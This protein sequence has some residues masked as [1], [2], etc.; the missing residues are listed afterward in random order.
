MPGSS[1]Q[2]FAHSCGSPGHKQPCRPSRIRAAVRTSPQNTRAW[3]PSG[4][5]AAAAGETRGKTRSSG[6]VPPALCPAANIQAVRSQCNGGRRCCNKRSVPVPGQA[7]AR[8]PAAA[9][10]PPAGPALRRPLPGSTAPP[11]TVPFLRRVRKRPGRRSLPGRAAHPQLPHTQTMRPPEPPGCFS[12]APFGP[13]PSA[14]LRIRIPQTSPRRHF[15]IAA[16]RA[17]LSRE[18]SAITPRVKSGLHR[19]EK[20]GFYGFYSV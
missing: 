2:R 7:P 14:F 5:K 19:P 1:G 4:S 17:I 20:D 18:A 9:H 10:M 8:A 13:P 15:F 12:K 11:K 6:A 3:L 16:A